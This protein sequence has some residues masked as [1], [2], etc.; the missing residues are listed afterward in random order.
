MIEF[1]TLFLGGLVTGPRTVEFV[2]GDPVAIVEVRLDGRL[3]GRLEAPAWKIRL[4]FGQDLSPHLLEG[5][6]L[7]LSAREVARVRQWINLSP[8]QAQ[9]TVLIEGADSGRDAVARVNWES[10][11]ETNEPESVRVTFDGQLLAVDD[12]RTIPLPEFDPRSTHYLRVKLEFAERLSSEAEVVFGGTYGSEV[13]TEITAVPVSLTTGKWPRSTES[14]NGWFTVEDTP[15]KIHAIEKGLGEIVA[16]VDVAASAHLA[17]LQKRVARLDTDI[18]VRRDLR[19]SFIN[20]CPE[21][22]RREDHRQIVFTRSRR[23]S[24]RDGRLLD[25]LSQSARFE[26]TEVEQQ[27]AEAVGIAGLT[28]SEDGR[29]RVVLLVLGEA[30]RDRSKLTPDQV[31]AYLR[32]LRVPLVVWSVGVGGTPPVQWGPTTGVQKLR[33]LNRAYKSVERILERQHVVWLEGSHLPQSVELRPGIDDIVLV[34]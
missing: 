32:R 33:L 2:A 16:V 5:V 28:A 11:A 4:D 7:D 29:R 22:Q 30:P 34:E 19:V 13:S 31:I 17:R 15:Q 18:G 27:L 1:V 26:C 8:K 23:F 10:L 12:P 20:P 9:S 3:A 21:T 6:G 14:M 25:L 24:S